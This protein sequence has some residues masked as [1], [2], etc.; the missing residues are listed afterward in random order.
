MSDAAAP[1]PPAG[2]KKFNLVLLALPLVAAGAGAAV[3]LVVDVPAL[4]GT[5]PKE[6]DPDAKAK[7]KHAKHEHLACVKVGDIAVNIGDERS[8][9]FLQVDFSVQCEHS[10]EGKLHEM[11]EKNKAAMKSWVIGHL[12]GKTLAEVK[13][14]VA[15]ARLQR[16]MLERFDDMLFPEGESPLRAVVFESYVIQ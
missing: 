16:E 13:G 10:A 2:K 7:K 5:K 14:A 6:H 3:P 9:R 1:A 15:I 11:V 4:L 8:S 12:A